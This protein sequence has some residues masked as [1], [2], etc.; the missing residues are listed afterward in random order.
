MIQPWRA[1]MKQPHFALIQST[2]VAA[3]L[4]R[5]NAD[6]PEKAKD[7][8]ALLRE[9]TAGRQRR[10]LWIDGVGGYLLLDKPEVTIGQALSGNSVD[11]GVVGDLSRQACSIRRSEGDYLLKT[12]ATADSQAGTRLLTECEVVELSPRVKMKFAKPNPLSATARLQLQSL[13]R[14]KPHVDGVLLLADSCILGPNLSCHVV[15]PNW[16]QEILLFQQNGSWFFRSSNPVEV[17]GATCNGVFPMVAGMRV[18]GDDFS[19]SVE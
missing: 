12:A 8:D 18:R 19:F 4:G 3:G 1:F 13:H 15:C 11:I 2:Q 10:V 7:T 16:S 17:S 5:K 6:G 14:F 9:S